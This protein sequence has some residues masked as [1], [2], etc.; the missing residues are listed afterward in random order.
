MTYK[1]S[2]NN[3]VESSTILILHW[4]NYLLNWINYIFERD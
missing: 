1:I 4:I 2:I 3:V